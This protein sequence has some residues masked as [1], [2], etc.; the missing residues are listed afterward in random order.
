MSGQMCC[1]DEQL[2]AVA[3]LSYPRVYR[4]EPHG[5]HVESWMLYD[6]RR[7]DVP[8][9]VVGIAFCGCG[10][11]VAE[12]NAQCLWLTG[13]PEGKFLP[14]A[15]RIPVPA[16]D[17]GIARLARLDSER[18][19]VCAEAS[20]TVGVVELG[21]GTT[22]LMPSHAPGFGV[23]S[24]ICCS[25]S[26]IFVV[27]HAFGS[28]Y[29]C[30]SLTRQGWEERLTE[31]TLLPLLC[32]AANGDVALLGTNPDERWAVYILNADRLLLFPADLSLEPIGFVYAGDE[33]YIL[34]QNRDLDLSLRVVSLDHRSGSAS[35]RGC[36]ALSP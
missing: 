17:R 8:D 7:Q 31:A 14:L 30:D 29:D 5:Q 11:V 24:D 3:G 20:D 33:C 19:V 26:R 1:G 36:I 23:A 25:G 12:D 15:Q 21:T 18:C 2:W 32:D 34:E 6:N 27:A 4:M 28:V 16:V 9:L 22:S 13:Q 10:L 35:S